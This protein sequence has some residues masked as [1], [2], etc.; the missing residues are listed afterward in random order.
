M[1][2]I[3]TLSVR[4]FQLLFAVVVL[5]LSVVLIKG[6]GPVF[7]GESVQKAP[8]LIDYGA[9]CGGAGI[10]IAVVGIAAAFFE[11]LQGI[12]TMALDGLATFFLLAG[13]IVSHLL[14]QVAMY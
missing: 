7:A 3:V 6:M 8:S 4:I 2:P 10:V 9:F 13:G 12:V 11:P 1:A 14:D 5:A